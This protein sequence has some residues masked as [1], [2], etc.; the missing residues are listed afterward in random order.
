MTNITVELCDYSNKFI[1]NNLYPLYLYDLAEIRDTYPNKY[2][3]FEEDDTIETLEEQIPIFDIW[4]NKKGILFPYLIKVDGLPA[5]F[6]L[7]ATPPYIVDDSD[8]M[9]S[10]MFIMR[11]FRSKGVGEYV[12]KT[13]FNKHSGT[14]MLFTTP[15][16]SNFKTIKFWRKTL[17]KCI[18]NQ[19]TE[20][21]QD[22]PHFGVNKIFK[23][24]SKGLEAKIT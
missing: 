6:I 9:I 3:V 5:G 11:P 21:D 14:W 24:S 15:T 20:V 23:L 18:N 10:E 2:G 17:S 22:I 1:I 4:W 8:F 13:I 19:F 12:V 16:D 7:V